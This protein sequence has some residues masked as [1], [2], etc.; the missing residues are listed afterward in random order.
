MEIITGIEEIDNQH[1]ELFNRVKMLHESYLNETNKEKLIETFNYIKTYINDHIKLEENYMIKFDYPNYK[2]HMDSHAEFIKKY[3][4]LEKLFKQDGTSSDFTLDFNVAIIDWLKVHVLHEDKVLADFILEKQ[5]HPGQKTDFN[6]EFFKVQK[7]DFWAKI[8]FSKQ[9]LN[10]FNAQDLINLEK[11]IRELTNYKSLKLIVFES[12]QKVFSAGVDVA[13]HLPE[14]VHEM[15]KAFNKLFNTLIS[16]EIPTLSLVK[17]GCFGGGS[18]FAL[19]CD[20][21]LATEEAYFSQPEICLGCFP[22]LS[23]AHLPYLTG[24]KKALEMV[25]TGEKI[26]A[27]DALRAGLINHVFPEEIFDVKAQAFINSIISNSAEVIKTTL[28]AYKKINYADLKGKIDLSE[29]IFVEELINLPDYKEGAES[30]IE[31]RAPVWQK[32]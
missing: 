23:M 6:E 1:K 24:N 31:N 12:D 9:P 32:S 14:K 4:A 26:A 7:Y 16:L 21:V 29:K 13:E 10:I 25:L 3:S 17:S 22:T 15:L 19:F 30:F 2:R 5:S 20:F 27:Y 8:T 11:I 18:E 28:K